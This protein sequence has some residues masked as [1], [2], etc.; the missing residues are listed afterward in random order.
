MSS[1]RAKTT[2]FGRFDFV[3]SVRLHIKDVVVY[4]GPAIALP[5]AGDDIHHDGEVVRIQ[6]VVWDFGAA[7]GVVSVTLVVGSQP[8]TV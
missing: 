1:P 7:D 2:E 8:Y 6:A 5:R 4:E 3:A